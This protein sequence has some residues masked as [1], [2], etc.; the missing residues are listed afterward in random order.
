MTEVILEECNRIG[1]LTD[2]SKLDIIKQ[3][4]VT[5]WKTLLAPYLG[6]GTYNV[7]KGDS[8]W[9]RVFYSLPKFRYVGKY[10]KAEW[11]PVFN[12]FR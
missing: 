5:N 6:I 11:F 9:L 10:S 12:A 1:S 4:Y 3:I 7:I 8:K 2:I